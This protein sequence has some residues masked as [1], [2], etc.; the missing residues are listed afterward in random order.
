ME[1][2]EALL[3]RVYKNRERVNR[4]RLAFPEKVKEQKQRE[5]LRHRKAYLRRSRARRLGPHR[6]AILKYYRAYG[7]KKRHAR[8]P[9]RSKEYYIGA[10]C[11]INLERRITHQ[12]AKEELFHVLNQYIC[13]RCGISDK[14]LLQFDHING[15][16]TKENKSIFR[17]KRLQFY[18]HYALNPDL[19]RK[20]LQVLCA[21]CNILKKF[22]GTEFPHF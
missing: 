17:N 9:D 3:K 18:M 2:S 20:T 8:I 15:G 12:K 10:K 13:Q 11:W 16:G 4:Y 19:A 21:N 5:Y 1:D 7:M 22:E 6:E 14:R